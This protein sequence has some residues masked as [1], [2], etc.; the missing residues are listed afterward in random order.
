MKCKGSHS[1]RFVLNDKGQVEIK[2]CPFKWNITQR[3]ISINDLLSQSNILEFAQSVHTLPYN[4]DSIPNGDC[5]PEEYCDWTSENVEELSIYLSKACNLHCRHCFQRADH[6]EIEKENYFK[7]LDR[8]RGYHLKVLTLTGVGEPL[9]YKKETFEYLKTLTLE[10]TE[11]VEIYT[12]GT[13]L[14]KSD[15][16]LLLEIQEKSEIK[17]K[18]SVSIDGITEE[19]F[20]SIRVGASFNKV[21]ENTKYLHEKGL[22]KD[23]NICIQNENFEEVPFMF[24]W[25]QDFGIPFEMIRLNP[26]VRNDEEETET[27]KELIELAIREEYS[28]HNMSTEY[29]DSIG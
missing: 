20:E 21:L 5:Y 25:W 17:I 16:D 2:C 6:S 9:F 22:L 10:D 18:L 24:T 28:K 4:D 11:S 12:N 19:T 7:V 14:D 13:L 15:I 23:I 27:A 29:L 8:I 26:V 1:V 3:V